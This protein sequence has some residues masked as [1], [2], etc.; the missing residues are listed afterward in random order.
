MRSRS[1]MSVS[2][3]KI[4]T[5]EALKSVCMR[6]QV[7]WDTRLRR[8]SRDSRRFG[9]PYLLHLQGSRSFCGFLAFKLTEKV[10]FTTTFKLWGAL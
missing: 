7:F 9:G 2:S 8:W 4:A 10:M 1:L 6:I 3:M 5:S